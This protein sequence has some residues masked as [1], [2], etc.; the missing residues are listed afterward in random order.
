MLNATT[1]LAC[2]F[3]LV[4]ACFSSFAHA[5]IPDQF[6]SE[7][8]SVVLG[9][10]EKDKISEDDVKKAEFENRNRKFRLALQWIEEHKEEF[11]GQWVVLDGGKLVSHGN[12]S[13]AVYDEARAKGYQSP[14][15][16]RVKAK[17]LPWGGW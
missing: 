10:G 5:K 12:D 8:A 14:F 13:K 16:E 17:V 6:K 7:T 3:A 15:M 2:L 11:D 9:L 4:S 1:K